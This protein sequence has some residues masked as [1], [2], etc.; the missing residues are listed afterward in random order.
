MNY[1]ITGT[2]TGVGKTFVTALLTRSLRAAG[3]DTIAFKPISCGPSDDLLILRA[4]ANN[5][6]N[7]DIVCPVQLPIAAA[8]YANERTG[9]P[10]V[11]VTLIRQ[12]FRRLRANHRSIL[13]EGVGGWL[14]PIRRYY[15]VHDLAKDLGLPVVIV[16][17][18]RL[19]ALNHTLLTIESI[20]ASGLT[21]AGIILNDAN[22]ASDPVADSNHGILQELLN[23][24]ILLEIAYGQKILPFSIA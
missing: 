6:L 18:N 10:P 12:T 11:D 9:Q 20:R 5:I 23:V 16:V 7:E 1:F 22:T 14:V 17:A 21:C 19:G 15:F 24:P 2:D 13:V 4:A 8:P 3:L